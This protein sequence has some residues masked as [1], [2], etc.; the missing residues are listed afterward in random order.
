MQVTR[1]PSYN[2]S[3][4]KP[5]IEEGSTTNVTIAG[6]QFQPAT[7]RVKSGEQVTWI[8][9][10]SMPHTVTSQTSNVLASERLGRGGAFTHTFDQPGTYTYYC[11]LHPSM[12]GR[13]IV[14]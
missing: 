5:S 8:N 4:A 9:A 2:T 11:A 14:E 7:I 10:E 6:M 1:Q 12:T 3:T 13:V